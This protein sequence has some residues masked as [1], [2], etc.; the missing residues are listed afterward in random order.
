[1]IA[2][3][4]HDFDWVRQSIFFGD[5][6][7]LRSLPRRKS[8]TALTPFSLGILRNHPVETT[9]RLI[10]RFGLYLGLNIEVRV[11]D[12]DDSFAFG[13]S[14]ASCDAVLVW[15][16]WRRIPMN[17][18][19][20]VIENIRAL[21]I[22]P[23]RMYVMCLEDDVLDNE[24]AASIASTL[25]DAG[26][27]SYP[28][29]S[30]IG[31]PIRASRI[32]EIAGSDISFRYQMLLARDLAVGWIGA[33]TTPTLKVIVVDLDNTLYSGVLGEDGAKGIKFESTHRDLL[34]T[35]AELNDQ[36]VL[37]CVCTHNDSRD[38]ETLHSVW[39]ELGFSLKDAALIR[40]TW[41]E[42]S[43]VIASMARE[44]R[45][46]PLSM[47]FLDDNPGELAKAIDL[48]PGIWP[49]LANSPAE[50]A[51]VLRTLRHRVSAKTDTTGGARA[52]D[53]RTQELRSNMALSTESITELHARL[54]TEVIIWEAA[55]PEIERVV[56][57]F[58]RTNQF[59]L[60]LRRMN[61]LEV[62]LAISNPRR[63]II[64]ASVSDKLSDSGIAAA[65]AFTGS[66]DFITVDELAIS[67]RLLGRDLETILIS[68][69]LTSACVGQETVV[70]KVHRGPRNDPAMRWVETFG[71]IVNA[72]SVSTSLSR[73]FA[74][75]R[76]LMDSIQVKYQS[77]RRPS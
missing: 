45:T 20:G 77:P 63:G 40:A 48:N 16:D 60:A 75:R 28:H 42:K 67:C 53:A 6:A 7:G 21:D 23:N 36:G 30:E 56:D 15:P 18:V 70:F 52:S 54:A 39:P 68:S 49:V 22:S 11:G 50:A 55:E 64:V 71:D 51:R 31:S 33:L 24:H 32:S 8:N 12:Y 26:L 59:N 76:G 47:A 14:V 43:S 38:I 9:A 44:L 58:H 69:M 74:A 57:L 62:S 3:G 35:L 29:L 25:G 66:E 27:A 61:V 4:I 72:D 34:Q 2:G 13:A 5:E 17:S 37:V 46:V 1:M 73:L 10:E 65:L 41:D 19:A